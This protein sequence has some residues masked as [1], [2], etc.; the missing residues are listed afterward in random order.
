[1]SI[2]E[3]IRRKEPVDTLEIENMKP[4]KAITILDDDYPECFKS[5]FRPPFVLYY[6]GN[7]ELLNKSKKLA[8]IGS[9]KMTK[10]G[11]DVSNYFIDKIKESG[12]DIAIVSGMARGIDGE[13]S[14]ACMRNGLPLISCVG[15]GLDIC[16]PESNKDIFEYC[17]KE[18]GLV[19]SEYPVGVP[20]LKENFP[21]RNRIISAL[22]NSI[23]VVEAGARSGTSITVNYACDQGKDIL[24]V[25]T[26]I[27]SNSSFTNYLIASGAIPCLEIDDILSSLKVNK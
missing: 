6:K 17:Q 16:Y 14:R 21:P 22:A 2:Y 11:K 12:H 1:M 25:P 15:S 3:A 7:R 27:F 10:Y 26:S 23:L 8:V 20:P 13:A 5:Q 18:N 9:R 4:I 24:C 19:L